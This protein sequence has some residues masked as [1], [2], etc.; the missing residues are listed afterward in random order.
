MQLKSTTKFHIFLLLEIV[1]A[2]QPL[3]LFFFQYF[4]YCR[5][6]HDNYTAEDPDQ[7]A[8]RERAGGGEVAGHVVA[9]PRARAAEPR[10][11]GQARWRGRTL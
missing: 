10:R 7:G 8:E 3:I 1:L 11:R 2:R 4:L 9:E 6:P 5:I